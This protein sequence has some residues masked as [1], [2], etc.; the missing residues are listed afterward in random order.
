MIRRIKNKVRQHPFITLLIVLLLIAL[1][2]G[3]I[4]FFLKWPVFNL[5]NENFWYLI[6]AIVAIVTFLSDRWESTASRRTQ[7]QLSFFDRWLELMTKIEQLKEKKYSP[8]AEKLFR[9]YF[10]LLH[11]EYLMKKHI[12]PTVWDF[13]TKYQKSEFMDKA[14]YA[15]KTF[16]DW[17]ETLK[18]EIDDIKFKKHIEEKLP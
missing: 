17:W 15:G 11:M 4:G 10:E 8:R 7:I 2:V 5:S 18:K 1:V 12:N 9:R 13:W 3:G 14:T 16:P 6:A